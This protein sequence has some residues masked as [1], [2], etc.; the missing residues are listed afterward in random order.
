M[1]FSASRVRNLVGARDPDPWRC[2]ESGS[3]ALHRIRNSGS[4]ALLRIQ[5]IPGAAQDPDPRR[6]SGSGSSALLR[7]RILSAAQD[8]DSRRCSG[9]RSSALLRI[10]IHGAAHLRKL[11][12][13]T[14]KE[15]L[16]DNGSKHLVLYP[17]VV[18]PVAVKKT[19]LLGGTLLGLIPA[20]VLALVRFIHTVS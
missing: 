11:G 6:C 5:K 12:S 1:Y 4:S 20:A 17:Y 9:S 18:G 14:L 15:G 19:N 7:I 10:R 3:P 13:R 8:P 16:N 2:S